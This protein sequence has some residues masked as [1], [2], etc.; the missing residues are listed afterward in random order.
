MASTAAATFVLCGVI[1]FIVHRCLRRRKKQEAIVVPDQ[2][3]SGTNNNNNG[4]ERIGGNV[5]GLIVDE[6]GLDVVYWRKLQGRSFK[7]AFKKEVL[8]REHQ[9]NDDDVD[10]NEGKKIE[11]KVQEFPLLRGKSS[12]SH[13][14]E[15][16]DYSN[17]K[18]VTARSNLPSVSAIP[19]RNS[20]APP[21]SSSSVPA[22]KSSPPARSRP[23]PVVSKPPPSSHETP[24]ASA[25]GDVPG[26]SSREGLPESGSSQVKLKPLHWDRM[27]SKSDVASLR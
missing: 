20:S 19:R 22:R 24:V 21:T 12:T 23:R 17:R 4:F 14:P 16:D 3:Q 10:V 13:L 27:N 25:A 11:E 18:V 6:N 9:N 26:N 2:N 5:K 8:N 1:F 7:G 15:G